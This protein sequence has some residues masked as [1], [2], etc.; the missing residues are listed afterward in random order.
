MNVLSTALFIDS[1]QN[2]GIVVAAVELISKVLDAESRESRSV[3]EM[4]ER[5]QVGRRDLGACETFRWT[6]AL[7]SLRVVRND[8]EGI[9]KPCL[10]L[11]DGHARRIDARE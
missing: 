6:E 4:F 10:I 3:G 7:T 2:L 1:K 5:P 8:E 11:H 9:G